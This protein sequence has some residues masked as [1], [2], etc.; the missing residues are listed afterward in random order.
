M[1]LFSLYLVFAST[2]YVLYVNRFYRVSLPFVDCIVARRRLSFPAPSV[3]PDFLALSD[4]KHSL[5]HLSRF[6]LGAQQHLFLFFFLI[7]W[8]LPSILS[9]RTCVLSNRDHPTS[10][11]VGLAGLDSG[12]R[13]RPA[14]LLHHVPHRPAAEDEALQALQQ[15]RAHL[16]PPLP[17]VREPRLLLYVPQE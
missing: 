15:L 2:F 14:E 6:V 11:G 1:C 4:A 17:L 16:R 12:G 9:C 8:L 13:P 10:S 3:T 5:R 7:S